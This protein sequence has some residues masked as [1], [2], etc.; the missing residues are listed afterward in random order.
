MRTCFVGAAAALGFPE[1]YGHPVFSQLERL[2]CALWFSYKSSIAGTL[3]WHKTSAR[4]DLCNVDGAVRL[5]NS[6]FVYF[7]WRWLTDS[8][9]S[10]GTLSKVNEDV[11]VV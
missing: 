11:E 1:L 4:F 8:M 7:G 5:S 10:D 2:Y 3:Y 6:G 9:N